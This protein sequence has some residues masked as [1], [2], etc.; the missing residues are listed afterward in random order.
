MSKATPALP[1]AF[2]ERDCV[3][4][5]RR[6]RNSAAFHPH[7]TLSPHSPVKVIFEI[8]YPFEIMADVDPAAQPA[9]QFGPQPDFAIMTQGLWAATTEIGKLA[10]LSSIA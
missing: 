5:D 7:F 8:V 4:Q 10:N 1:I 6:K 9:A 2:R 3:E